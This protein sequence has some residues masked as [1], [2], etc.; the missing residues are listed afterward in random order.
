MWL[1][2][3]RRRPFHLRPAG[4]EQ[5]SDAGFGVFLL[6]QDL[7]PVRKP[8]HLDWGKPVYWPLAGSLEL[9]ICHD[10]ECRFANINN[11]DACIE[12]TYFI[13]L[14]RRGHMLLLQDQWDATFLVA[15]LS[16]PF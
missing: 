3:V 12:H 8:R 2:A 16:L 11:G 5:Y 6:E 1:S 9:D 4:P 13:V 14:R 7:L 10:E 15:L